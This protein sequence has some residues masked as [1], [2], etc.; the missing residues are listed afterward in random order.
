M[1]RTTWHGRRCGGAVWRGNKE[2]TNPVKSTGMSSLWSPGFER[3]TFT[4]AGEA[5]G[6]VGAVGS[7]H[8][9]PPRHA[10]VSGSSSV[11]TL[12]SSAYSEGTS[13]LQTSSPR[14]PGWCQHH[15][16]HRTTIAIA[17]IIIIIITLLLPG[18]GNDISAFHVVNCDG[19]HGCTNGS[20]A[21]ANCSGQ[22]Q[23]VV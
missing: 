4:A 17:I 20:S 18:F 1:T 5:A 15:H 14:R 9:A 6:S 11:V 10:A 12:S 3:P 22:G 7:I 23:W 13:G 8:N 21:Q 19:E 2:M 16:R